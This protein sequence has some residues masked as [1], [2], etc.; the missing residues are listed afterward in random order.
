MA[1]ILFEQNKQVGVVILNRPLAL[2][3][4]TL[5]MVKSLQVQLIK[6][7]N[8]QAIEAVLVKSSSDKAFCAGGDVRWLYDTGR[9]ND[10]EQMQFFWHEYRLNHFIKHFPKPYISLL[11]GITMGG[12]VGISLHGSYPI[13]TENFSFAMPET[14]IGFFPDIGGG[15]LL[16][17][18]KGEIGTYLALTG[19]RIGVGD[20]LAA[21]LITHAIARDD[22]SKII[23]GLFEGQ[24]IYS[25]L[26]SHRLPQQS[27][28]LLSVEG[29]INACF[30]HDSVEQILSALEEQGSDWSKKTHSLL[31]SKSPT[32]LKVTLKQLRLAK[33]RT[34]GECMKMEYQMV[35]QF[36]KQS[37]FYEGVRALLVDKDKKPQW[38]PNLLSDVTEELV[39]TYFQPIENELSLI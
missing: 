24:G 33:S 12:G 6:W 39:D 23:S 2:N 22:L 26:S 29:E 5:D 35:S 34:M 15:Y 3:A 13:A 25:L 7:A 4:L 21:G 18:A 28:P 17:R 8:E 11:D 30:C 16:S 36:M 14:G 20:A 37:D 38:H 9:L 19:K 1:D 32:S 27:T 31:L 10:P